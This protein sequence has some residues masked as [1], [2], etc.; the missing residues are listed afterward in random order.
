MDTTKSNA[1]KALEDVV[2][3]R[4]SPDAQYVGMV[5]RDGEWVF[6]KLF[7]TSPAS[8]AWLGRQGSPCRVYYVD[9][10]SKVLLHHEK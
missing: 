3:G 7:T 6:A 1:R 10:R 5:F 9:S 2:R 4:R 8:A